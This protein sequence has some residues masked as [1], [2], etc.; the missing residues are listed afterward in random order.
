[1]RREIVANITNHRPPDWPRQISDRKHTKDGEQLGSALLAGEEVAADRGGKIAVNRKIVPLNHVSD[2]ACSDHL[3][4]RCGI[5]LLPIRR[6]LPNRKIIPDGTINRRP[7]G[8]NSRLSMRMSALGHSRYFEREVGM[9]ASPM[10]GHRQQRSARPGRA[11]TKLMHRSKTATYSM[12][13]VF[14]GRDATKYLPRPFT[15]SSMFFEPERR[16]SRKLT[17]LNLQVSK[18]LRRTRYS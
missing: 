8:E 7:K 14:V 18:T 16:K 10:N 15:N 5:H 13:F 17:F 4:F 11:T 3:A 1:M 12:T 9:T 6:R 2:H